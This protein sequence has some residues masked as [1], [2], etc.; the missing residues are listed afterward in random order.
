[1]PR[2]GC[3][4]V[5]RKGYA[6]VSREGYAAVS[7]EGYAAVSREGY[8]AVSREGFSRAFIVDAGSVARK[9]ICS[10]RPRSVGASRRSRRSLREHPPRIS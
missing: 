2:E 4:A 1:M 7:R 9:V 3:A 8:A 6:A 5:P 10:E